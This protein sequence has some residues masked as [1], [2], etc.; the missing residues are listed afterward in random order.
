M[1]LHGHDHRHCQCHQQVLP[2]VQSL[3][4]LDFLK[5]ACSAAQKGDVHRLNDLLKRHA[6]SVDDD[7]VGGDTRHEPSL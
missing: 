3:D 6:E 5:S 7:G 4:E 1:E 2:A